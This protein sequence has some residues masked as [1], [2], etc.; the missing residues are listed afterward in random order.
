MKIF[1]KLVSSIITAGLMLATLLTPFQGAHA[2][3][4]GTLTFS[5]TKTSLQVGEQVTVSVNLAVAGTP[6]AGSIRLIVNYDSSKLS[7]VNAGSTGSVFQ[8]VDAEASVAGQYSASRHNNSGGTAGG[9]VVDLTFQATSAGTAAISFDAGS[10]VWEATTGDEKPVTKTATQSLTISNV[11]ATPPPNPAPTV[12]SFAVSPTKINQGASATLSWDVSNASSVSINQGIGNVSAK[13]S[14]VVKPSVTTTYTLTATNSGGTTTRSATLTVVTP[15]ATPKPATPTPKPTVAP[16]TIATATAT[17]TPAVD[18]NTLSLSQ[19]SINFSSTTAVAD[20]V[21][22]ITVTVNLKREN[23]TPASDIEPIISGLRD[24][25]D[26]ASPFVYSEA[27]GVWTSFLTSTQVGSTTV[28]I[29]A[30]GLNLASQEV[31]FT[32]PT[33]TPEPVTPT[34]SSGS[35]FWRLLLIG[36]GILILLLLILFFVWRRLHRDDEEEGDEYDESDPN[37]P[38]FPGDDSTT[39]EE[40][41]EQGTQESAVAPVPAPEEPKEEANAEFN[42]DQ[43]LQRTPDTA[44]AEQ[45]QNNDTIPL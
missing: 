33:S 6:G 32:E 34:D 23:G 35:S 22:T 17:P 1:H 11:T 42:A 41:G 5:T 29:S 40:A 3:E 15:T 9:K 7:L 8:V 24:S 27:D 12:N 18:P 14:G 13:S 36:L 31:T 25:G 37:A 20:G 44:P 16:T 43:T 39:S 19:S 38:A 4:S 21:D 28:T 30:G 2:M 26:A 45:P 10:K